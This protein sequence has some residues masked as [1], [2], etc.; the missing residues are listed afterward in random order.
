MRGVRDRRGGGDHGLWRLA[1]LY[2]IA[3]RRTGAAR[4]ESVQRSVRCRP[5]I[6][7]VDEMC[8]IGRAVLRRLPLL[9]DPPALHHE[10][11]VGKRPGEVEI[12]LDDHDRDP[13][14]VAYPVQGI[15][16][17]LADVWLASFG[18]FIVQHHR[19]LSF[20]GPAALPLLLLSPLHPF[21]TR[22]V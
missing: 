14:F 15:L 3:Y 19:L 5:A 7:D 2:R 9:H 10:I 22:F 1:G 13:E 11:T 20:L 18:L 17:L 12:L 4:V 16:S 8:D 21:L 6:L